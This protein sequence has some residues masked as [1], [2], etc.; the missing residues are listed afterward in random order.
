MRSNR[1][2]YLLL[3]YTENILIS[4]VFVKLSSCESK[5]LYSLQRSEKEV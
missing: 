2:S 5:D 1:L 3:Y 4:I